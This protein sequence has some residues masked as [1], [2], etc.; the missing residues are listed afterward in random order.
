MALRRV[1]LLIGIFSLVVLTGWRAAEI[2]AAEAQAQ[3][4]ATE[5]SARPGYAG[6]ASCASCHAKQGLSYLH[7]AHAHTSS[8]MGDEAVT[9]SF[10]A[11]GNDL[12]ISDPAPAIGDPGIAYRMER[13]DASY[14]VSAIT[15]F[16]GDLQT[17]SERMDLV[18]GSG[19]RGE[20]YLSWRGDGLFE[21]P[22]SYWTD[23]KQWINSPGYRNGS[24]NFDRPATARCLE[25]H[26]SYAEALS[27]DVRANR[28][29][30]ASVQPGISCEVCHGP[31][32]RHAAL[33]A[34]GVPT[35]AADPLILNPKRFSRDRQVDLCALC[36][37]GA[38]QQQIAAAFTY[39][40]GQ[41]LSTY[42]REE[43]ASNDTRPDVHANQVGL[44]KRS[45]CYLSSPAMTCSTCHEVH[46]PEQAAASY[47]G[48][49]LGCH[50]VEDCGIEQTQGPGIAKDCVSCHMP[51]QQTNAIVSQTG[52]KLIRT[53]MRTHWIKVYPALD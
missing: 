13:K 10:E 3:H 4:A 7:T 8:R 53:R 49:C 46:A 51:I 33:F 37:N 11:G 25:C 36:H 20:S 5:T 42:L 29:V 52:D 12:K 19:V 48:K 14:Y 22:V 45:K 34:K 40:P 17:R 50:R 26:F 41:P 47:S 35:K 18:V 6:D 23:G 21:L 1:L 28:F 9:G 43:S 39:V 44:L 27:S 24:P 38:S 16:K 32:A 15:G 31:G 30:R 2:P